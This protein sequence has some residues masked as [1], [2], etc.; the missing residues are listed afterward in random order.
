MAW[1]IDQHAG[2]SGR[3]AVADDGR[4]AVAEEEEGHDGGGDDEP[5]ASLRALWRRIVPRTST[6]AAA[7]PRVRTRKP[8]LLSRAFRV[9]SCGGGGRA[10]RRAR[11]W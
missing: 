3:D 4:V 9:L 8:G 7:A 2:A 10:A 5:P 11:R 1:Q 6:T